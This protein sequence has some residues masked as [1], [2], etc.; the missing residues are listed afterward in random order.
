MVHPSFFRLIVRMITF[1]SIRFNAR[2]YTNPTVIPH[3]KKRL[4]GTIQSAGEPL[5]VFL[6]KDRFTP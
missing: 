2:R 5:Y 4:S 6:Q 3:L 1:I